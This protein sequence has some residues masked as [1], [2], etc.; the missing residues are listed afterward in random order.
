MNC[1]TIRLTDNILYA[2]TDNELLQQCN[3][4]QDDADKGLID[5]L[6]GF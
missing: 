4:T 2:L 3:I 1:I 5:Q 6:K